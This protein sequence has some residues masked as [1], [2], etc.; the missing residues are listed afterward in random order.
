VTSIVFAS[1]FF[2]LLV[3][4]QKVGVLVDG[5]AAAVEYRLDGKPIGRVEKAPWELQVD[6]GAD[7]S[8]H[9][10]VARALD[11]EGRELARARQWL[12][13]PRE[14]A[15]T[16]IAFER[17]AAGRTVAARLSWQSIVGS[18]PTALSA[19]FDGKAVAVDGSGRI[20]LPPHDPDKPHVLSVELEFP[21]GLRSRADAVLGGGSASEA[22]TELTAIAVRMR[23]GNDFPP[24]K[25]LGGWFQVDGRPLR[26]VAV[27][28]EGGEVLIVRDRD[29]TE[30]VE[31]LDPRPYVPPSGVRRPPPEPKGLRYEMGLGGGIRT[32][33]VWPVP[34]RYADERVSSNH[35]EISR[36]RLDNLY[37]VLTRDFHPEGGDPHQS[38]SDATAVAGLVAFGTSAR[39]AVVLVLG[40][41]VDSSYYAP[42]AVRRYLASVRV[43]L[44]VWSL[45][46][47]ATRPELS[48]WGAVVDI[49]SVDKLR[50]AFLALK[51]DLRSQRVVW[52]E[53]KHLPQKIAL[54]EK[55][56]G[57]DLVP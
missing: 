39:R 16:K 45:V 52:F 10:L 22:Q 33:F 49:S 13:L 48:R 15:E 4:N 1:L 26:V 27:D 11:S 17:N 56:V 14:R 37:Y 47:P 24:P 20:A 40:T 18:K 25:A 32:R 30:A 50:K 51:A 53:G 35:F 34:K 7:L 23:K 29:R 57:I 5:P 55:A 46:D 2:G 6:L 41:R 44:H 36:R 8:P 12:N 42:E 3:G 28:D 21:E 38:F 54:T 9:E 19:T 31:V 43:P